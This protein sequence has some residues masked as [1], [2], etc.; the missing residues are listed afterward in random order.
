M[1]QNQDVF[2]RVIQSINQVGILP[3][4]DSL[5]ANKKRFVVYEAI[6]MSLGGIVW[7]TFCCFF[8]ER[9]F[10]SMIPYGY[11]VLSAFNV[12]FFAVY[13]KFAYVQAFQ[14]GISLLLPFMFQWFLGGFY[15]SGG[16]M[17][18]SL[19]ALAASLS[20]SN[21]RASIVWLIF[22]VILTV[23]TGIYDGYFREHFSVEY[24]MDFMVMIIVAN[25]AVVSS[26]ILLLVIFYV[27]ENSKYYAKVK[28]A[29]Q[30]LIQSEKLAALGQLSAGIAHEI[31]TPLG[32]I[33]AIAQE[34]RAMGKNLV[35]NLLELY[36]CLS[37]EEIQSFL[38]IVETY[39][40]KNE[41]LSTREERPLRMVLQKELEQRNVT[42][43]SFLASKLSQIGM[44]TIEAPLEKL[45]GPH[46]ELVVDTLHLLFLDE[47]NNLTTLTSVEKASRVVRALKM[48]LHSSES[49]EPERYNL[50][51]SIDTVLT[52]YNNQL[53][54]G[55][56]VAIDV[57][58]DIYLTGYAEEIG[59]VWTNLIVNACQAMEF[60]GTLVIK[61]HV[62]NGIAHVAISDTGCG[63]P[64]E[65]GD[66]V[67]DAFYSTKKIGEGSGLGLDIVKNIILKHNG[68][69]FF[70]SKV[71]VGTTFFIELPNEISTAA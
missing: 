1:N 8:L 62:Q 68:K 10:P 70:E 60:S 46:F 34:S 25:I 20:Y 26:S 9:P 66:R 19:L 50:R 4:D 49:N 47:K 16:V 22:Y 21:I 63:I 55:I 44:F 48:Y 33:K 6:L 27:K 65:I 36:R 51:E 69:I 61:A 28:D 23:F 38:T 45:V 40:I 64:D 42:Q 3:T 13:K 17:I 39:K 12:G 11:V 18:W 43:A 53:K 67:F 31:N 15:S 52:I 29:Q 5:L 35:S 71:N 59:Q 24:S 14:T 7:G 41:F 2:Q 37:P 58:D 30:M 56:R 54:H 57:S 32:A